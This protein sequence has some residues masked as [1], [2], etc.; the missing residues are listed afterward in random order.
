MLFKLWSRCFQLSLRILGFFYT[1]TKSSCSG[2]FTRSAVRHMFSDR[3]LLHTVF[4][5]PLMFTIISQH[6][7]KYPSTDLVH[8]LLLD[9][10]ALYGGS[11]ALKA[12]VL[13]GCF[14]CILSAPHT[15]PRRRI[16]PLRYRGTDFFHFL[17]RAC[18]FPSSIMP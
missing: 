4:W 6:D 7:T 9:L 8:P 17:M 13:C 11:I 3:P 18:G 14:S 1:L 5:L 10:R 12:G 15:N 2:V 16:S